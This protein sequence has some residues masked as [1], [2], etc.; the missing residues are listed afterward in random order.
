M[1]EFILDSWLYSLKK[2]NR[3]LK[4][5]ADWDF[6][7]TT[8]KFQIHQIL[9]TAEVAIINENE[10]VEKITNLDEEKILFAFVIYSDKFLHY[11]YTKQNMR[12][13]NFFT[14]LLDKTDLVQNNILR[15]TYITETLPYVCR[16]R[17]IELK[18]HPIT[19]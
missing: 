16:A 1:R 9:K 13:N 2:G 8:L 12:R 3:Y 11:A 7:K 18:Y 6:F 17:N 5:Y 19:T 4:K 14:K 15:C 10:E